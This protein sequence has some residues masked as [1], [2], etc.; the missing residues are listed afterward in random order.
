M[1]ALHELVIEEGE[2]RFRCNAAPVGE[3]PPSCWF[4]YEC[5]GEGNEVC[6][7]NLGECN[8]GLWIG[9][10]GVETEGVARIPVDV[11]WSSDGPV[12]R[13]STQAEVANGFERCD[14]VW[15]EA[16]PEHP[17]SYCFIAEG[18]IV[19]N[20]VPYHLSTED[21]AIPTGVRSYRILACGG[22]DFTDTKTIEAAVKLLAEQH[23]AATLV[24]GGAPGADS[25]CG[26]YAGLAGLVIEGHSARWNIYGR[27]AG[28]I[29][30]QEM[31]DSGIDLVVAFPGGRGTSDMVRRARKAHVPVWEV[32][33]K[34]TTVEMVVQS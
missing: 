21:D 3:E 5:D 33:P 27:K 1:S 28:P 8:A 7:E 31:L 2:L 26:Y 17:V 11:L 4:A 22:R 19:H 34:A 10:Q 32:D 29:R 23:P 6:S 16:T 30:N 18:H 20:H 12:L 13:P 9:E 15:L 24:H 14:P 25:W